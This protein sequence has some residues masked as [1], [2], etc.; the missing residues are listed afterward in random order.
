MFDIHFY[1]KVHDL[2][3][4]VMN[5][6]KIEKEILVEKLEDFRSREPVVYNI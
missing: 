3:Y 5:G 1:M 4:R 6:E 2:K